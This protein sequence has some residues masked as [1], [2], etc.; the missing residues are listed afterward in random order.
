MTATRLAQAV[1]IGALALLA[2]TTAAAQPS[3]LGQREFRNSCAA[4]HGASGR[5]EGAFG[6][7]MEARVP[8]LTVLAKKNGGVFPVERVY[9]TIDGTRMMKAHGTSDMPIWGQRYRVEAAKYYV[10][11]PYDEA[12]FVRTRIL[13]LIDYLSALQVK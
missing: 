8:D 10:D 2:T 3:K 12:M 7:M 4:C 9:E 11:A 1:A 13:A 5:G 6:G